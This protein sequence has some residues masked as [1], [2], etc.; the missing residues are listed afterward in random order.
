M[1]V[2]WAFAG[3]EDVLYVLNSLFST[4]VVQAI[5]SIPGHAMFGVVMGFYL[6]RAK[7]GR[8]IR[9]RSGCRQPC[10]GRFRPAVLHGLYDFL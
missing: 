6:S 8:E 7:V 4:A 10:A 9:P 5:F 2:S 1:F 3:V